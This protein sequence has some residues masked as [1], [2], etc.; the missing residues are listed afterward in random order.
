MCWKNEYYKMPYETIE[1]LD[2]EKEYKTSIVEL[3]LPHQ[4]RKFFDRM[5]DGWDIML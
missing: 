5:V 3:N 4:M 1:P 2:M